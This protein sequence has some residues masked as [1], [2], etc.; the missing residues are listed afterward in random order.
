MCIRD[1][2][3]F[4]KSDCVILMTLLDFFM[5]VLF[6]DVPIHRGVYQYHLF[7]VDFVDSERASSRSDLLHITI[8]QYSQRQG[9]IFVRRTHCE[10]LLTAFLL[11]T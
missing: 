6:A 7:M 11:K 1:S 10:Q 8:S 2:N 5:S 9:N 3:V 4:V